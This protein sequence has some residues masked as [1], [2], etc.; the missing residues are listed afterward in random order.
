MNEKDDAVIVLSGVKIGNLNAIRIKCREIHACRALLPVMTI[1]SSVVVGYGRK[2]IPWATRP[3]KRGSR[4]WQAS[5][6]QS[7]RM[8]K[9]SK[10]FLSACGNFSALVPDHRWIIRTSTLTWVM[11]AKFFALI[12]QRFLFTMQN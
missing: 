2:L 9:A 11:T 10:R 5:R 12:A 4:L 6:F 1:A 3:L 7:S 8:K